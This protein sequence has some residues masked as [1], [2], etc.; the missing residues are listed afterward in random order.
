M[1]TFYFE[2]KKRKRFAAPEP[3]A[4]IADTHTHLFL[5]ETR[6][7]VEQIKRAEAVGVRLLGV[8]VDPTASKIEADLSREGLNELW[9]KWTSLLPQSELLAKTVF[10]YGVHPYGAADFTREVHTALIEAFESPHV[11]SIGEIGLDYTCD[12]DKKVQQNVFQTQLNLAHDFSLPV[13]LHIRDEK[14]DT[15]FAAHADAFKILEK[16]GLPEA[17]ADLHCF[18]GDTNMLLPFVELGCSVAFGGAA[19]FVKDDAIRDAACACPLDR[20]LSETDSP[21]MAPVPLRGQECEP[22]MVS[23]VCACL[24]Q[25]REDAGIST[26]KETYEALWQ[27]ANRFFGFEA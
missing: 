24:A 14:D 1:A 4:P 13:E 17:G 27:N 18:T 22:A 3:L 19:T 15:T 10:V 6:S 11:K 26:Q 2:N 12:V 8:P 23:F 21:Y 9:E 25:V 16:T 20:L 5:G 7:A